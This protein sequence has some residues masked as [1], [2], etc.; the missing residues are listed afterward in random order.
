MIIGVVLAFV[1]GLLWIFTGSRLLEIYE[2]DMVGLVFVIGGLGFLMTV[3][4]I[5]IT[6]DGPGGFVSRI[7]ERFGR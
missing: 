5:A 7:R 1:A 2:D 4:Q 6:S 3:A